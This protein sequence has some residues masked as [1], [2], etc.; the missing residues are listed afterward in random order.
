MSRRARITRTPDPPPVNAIRAGTLDG[1]LTALARCGAIDPVVADLSMGEWRSHELA[2]SC[3]A[4]LEI[5]WPLPPVTPRDPVAAASVIGDWIDSEGRGDSAVRVALDLAET[6]FGAL[7]Q[8][9]LS[10]VVLMP[11]FASR[12]QAESAA[13]LRYLAQG[14]RS[15][16][17]LILVGDEHAN[18][19]PCAGVALQ[20][21]DAPAGTPRPRPPG[22]VALVPGTVDPATARALDAGGHPLRAGWTLV[23]PEWRRAPAVTSRL[24]FDRLAAAP[25]DPWLRAF[26]QVHGNNYF[27]DSWFLCA[28]AMQRLAEG[29]H[30]IALELMD[31][32]AACS[33]SLADRAILSALAQGFRIA[34]MRYGEAAAAPDPSPALPPLQRGALH[35]TKG[36]GLVM[37]GQA[38][39]AEP[40]LQSA[41][42]LL[43]AAVGRNR[44][45]LYLVNI[46]AL[47]R[48]NLGD[49]E[50]A[51]AMEKQIEADSA[52]LDDVDARFDYVN[53]I[54]IARLYR[55]RN[56]FELA[57]TYY[58][59]AFATTAGA[60]TESDLVYA[61]VCHA[62]LD[63]ARGRTLDCFHAW[64]RA[65][66]HW[67]SCDAPEALGWRVQSAILGRKALPASTPVEHVA[68]AL[69]AHLRSAAEAAMCFDVGN[70]LR[71]CMGRAAPAPPPAV[72]RTDRARIDR[73]AVQAIG[74]PGFSVF[75]AASPERAA[76]SGPCQQALASMVTAFIAAAARAPALS[77]FPTILVDDG[78]GQEM[79]INRNELFAACLRLSVSRARFDGVDY[80]LSPDALLECAVIRRGPAVARYDRGHVHFKRYFAPR[81]LSVAEAEVIAACDRPVLLYALSHEIGRPRDDVLGL[82][83]ALEAARVLEIRL[84]LP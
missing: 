6:L 31:R 77:D 73:D 39:R 54:N 9:P 80:E 12:W 55:R 16:D 15:D 5:P 62:R 78:G 14:A 72:L 76:T 44:Q 47:N 83:R 2:R 50:G 10:L 48:L 81:P 18:A 33:S 43:E 7:D 26:A 35:M 70:A 22:L 68:G 24:E 58:A 30:G 13:F 36:W 25:V 84:E 3:F 34:L 42:E 63:V 32:A 19:Q 71:G 28:E 64:L 60:R 41:S 23:P 21:S 65:S 66:L 79:P 11:R 56:E 52:A 40:Y 69:A 53:S 46:S 4:Q 8:H 17:R 51:L 74:A 59:R 75:A 29:S 45:F 38:A 57:A 37:T 67:L 82:V 61:N 20:W 27:V 49:H 1:L